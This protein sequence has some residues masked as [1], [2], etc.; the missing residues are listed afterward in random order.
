MSS[1]DNIT[2]KAIVIW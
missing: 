1:K 2:V